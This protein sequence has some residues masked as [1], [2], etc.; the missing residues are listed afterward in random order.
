MEFT[1]AL[2]LSDEELPSGS[3][4][5]D[6]LI[7]NQP[8]SPFEVFERLWR[9]SRYRICADGGAN[10]LFDIFDGP[11]EHARADFLPSIIHGDLDSLRDDVRQYY[12]SKGVEVSQDPDQYSTDFRKAIRKIEKTDLSSPRREVLILGTLSG[13]VDQGLGLLHEMTREETRNPNL[14]LWLISETNVSWILRPGRNT[15]ST[16]LSAGY[17]T[18]NVGIVPV[19]GPAQITT[20]GLEWDVQDWATQMGHQVSTSNHAM[21]EQV[22]VETDA[23]VLFTIERRRRLPEG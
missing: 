11:L 1:P 3:T 16:G 2:F 15:I 23:S 6:L 21:G 13:R 12:S 4:V 9:H 7:L 19:Y 8:I 5:P 20:S 18:C 17:F 10:R 14:R 22:E